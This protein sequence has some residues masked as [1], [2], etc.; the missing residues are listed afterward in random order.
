MGDKVGGMTVH[1][2]ARILQLA[3]R[4]SDRGDGHR[5]GRRRRRRVH[6][7]RPGHVR[8]Q[9]P[10]R[11]VAGL[12]G[13][14]GP[15]P[16]PAAACDPA[17]DGRASTRAR[18]QGAAGSRSGRGR[19]GPALVAG[20]AGHERRARSRRGRPE[21][22]R[23]GRSRE[24]S[25]LDGLHGGRRS[26]DRRGHRRRLGV[27]AQ[28]VRTRRSGSSTP[29]PTPSSGPL[30]CPGG[31]P[32][33]APAPTRCGSRNGFGTAGRAAAAVL[34]VGFTTR[35]IEQQVPIANGVEGDRRAVEAG[36]G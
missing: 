33:S 13:R 12:R 1:V 29:R 27:G 8:A 36:S 30:G 19:G 6:V 23:A 35:R 26:T 10:S 15:P 3:E 17:V 24:R 25:K 32:A 28:P 5:P 7:R 18:G 2:G 16:P 22:G 9:G 21:L 14:S 20:D 34:R 11:G 4:R 31:P